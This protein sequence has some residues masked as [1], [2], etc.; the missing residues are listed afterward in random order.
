[1]WRLFRAF[2]PVAK[3]EPAALT[4]GPQMAS[5]GG[6]QTAP[7][8]S[9]ALDPSWRQVGHSTI[10]IQWSDGRQVPTGSGSLVDATQ[11]SGQDPCGEVP[12]LPHVGDQGPPAGWSGGIEVD[13][14]E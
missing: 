3:T 13:M 14:A 8:G 6:P 11:S 9:F 10:T 4:G 7:L 5:L 1:M 2:R 12:Q